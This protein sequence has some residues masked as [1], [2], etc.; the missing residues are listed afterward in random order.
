[1]LAKACHGLPL[2]LLRSRLVPPNS[3][4]ENA[5]TALGEAQVPAELDVAKFLTPYPQ[6]VGCT[7]LGV[8]GGVLAMVR[9]VPL[10][11]RLLVRGRE[12]VVGTVGHLV[13]RQQQVVE[14]GHHPDTRWICDVMLY[15]GRGST[16]E[17]VPG[18]H[19]I[20]VHEPIDAGPVYAIP[21]GF[22]VPRVEDSFLLSRK[23]GLLERLSESCQL[24]MFVLPGC[25]TLLLAALCTVM[26]PVRV[27][28]GKFNPFA[29]IRSFGSFLGRTYGTNG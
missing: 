28:G 4:V 16:E 24:I 26:E 19:A 22:T 10:V 17:L 8:H 9:H 21:Q 27:E 2:L 3:S 25:V 23:P 12:H 18:A 20:H 1:M 5:E 7:D 13:G 14:P 15:M 11:H 6:E 29:N